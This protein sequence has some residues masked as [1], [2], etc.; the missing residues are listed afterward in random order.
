M[1]IA[2]ADYFPLIRHHNVWHLVIMI[3]ILKIK[4]RTQINLEDQ[5]SHTN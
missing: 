2:I 1:L 4:G 5:R 3:M